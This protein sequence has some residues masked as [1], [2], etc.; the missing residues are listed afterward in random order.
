[1]VGG[2]HSKKDCYEKYRELKAETRLKQNTARKASEVSVGSGSSRG[3]RH[4]VSGYDDDDGPS[5]CGPATRKFDSH[6]CDLTP[7]PTHAE[8]QDYF[9]C[10]SI[11]AGSVAA[12]AGSDIRSRRCSTLSSW[13]LNSAEHFGQQQQQQQQHRR[14]S[15]SSTLSSVVSNPVADTKSDG[16]TGSAGTGAVTRRGG[17]TYDAPREATY[18]GELMEVEE[19]GV[20]DFCLDDELLVEE[21]HSTLGAAQAKFRRQGGRESPTRNVGGRV[22][23]GRSGD[24]ERSE[25]STVTEV[26]ANGVREL[27][28]GKTSKSFNDA[29]RDQGFYF[30]G[31][32]GLRYGLVQAEGGPCGVLAVVQ[33]FL[34][35]VNFVDSS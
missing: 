25:I 18:Q 10:A 26:E 27:V 5:S 35:E 23:A 3:H 9:E 19:V 1:M 8:K 12:S 28:F 20:E 11:T 7:E 6:N 33:A 24:M 14:S 30:C 4:T 22:G 34:L 32:D 2:N 15:T 31:V 21:N 16:T 17:D 29:W 13:S